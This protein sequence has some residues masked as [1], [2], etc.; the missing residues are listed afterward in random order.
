[1][2]STHNILYILFALITMMG[3]TSCDKMDDN[4]PFEGCWLLLDYEG[5]EG[6]KP[7]NPESQKLV[8]EGGTLLTDLPVNTQEI[9]TWS[10]R[11]QLIQIRNQSKGTQ[12][13]FHFTRTDRSLLLTDA[14]YN[15]GSQ[16][17][18]IELT[19]LPPHFCIPADGHFDVPTL[20]STTMVLKAGE[21]TMTFK[22]N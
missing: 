1:M 5:Y 3:L 10:V 22:K 20:T 13:Y 9:I 19:E 14:F 18:K 21:V 17:T 6:N 15:D 12:Y 4:G 11:N 16:D 2:K 7:V 8:T